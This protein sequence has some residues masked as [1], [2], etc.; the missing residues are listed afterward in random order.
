M[1]A[2]SVLRELGYSAQ[3][4]GCI[5]A[6]RMDPLD[7]YDTASHGNANS[8]RPDGEG[9]RISVFEHRRKL[10]EAVQA[11]QFRQAIELDIKNIKALFPGKYDVAIEQMLEEYERI[12][13]ALEYPG[14]P[15]VGGSACDPLPP[16][17]GGGDPQPAPAPAPA[18]PTITPAY[19]E[20]Y[21]RI[22][23]ARIAVT[24]AQDPLYDQ[25]LVVD[26]GDGAS[27]TIY[28]PEGTGHRTVYTSNTYSLNNGVI[29]GLGDG[30]EWEWQAT[31]YTSAVTGVLGDILVQES[32]RA[33]ATVHQ[34]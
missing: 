34:C 33:N 10:R 11:G 2:S 6:I 18:A 19:Q 23:T 17:S 12:K 21:G 22:A 27:S 26:F 4:I 30:N 20:I 16:G 15:G 9:G 3:T 8:T 25:A 1:P 31:A 32:R 5:P 7:H 28:I 29:G 13:D 24:V 14:R